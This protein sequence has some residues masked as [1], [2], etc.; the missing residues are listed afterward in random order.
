VSEHVPRRR[1]TLLLHRPAFRSLFLATLG[2]GVGT[3][4]AA[5]VLT[6][7]IRDKTHSGTWVAALLVADLLPIFLIGVTLGPLID[8]LSRKRLMIGADLVRLGVFAVL[9][10]A[11]KPGE[12]V[13]LAAITGVATGFFKPAVFAGVPNL[14]DGDDEL[15]VANSL[16]SGIDNLAWMVGPLIGAALLVVS[17]PNL[18]YWINAATFLLSAVLIS[19]IPAARLQ[20][21]ESLSRGHWRDV[22]D[23]IALVL[24]TP[25]LRTVLIV[26]NVVIVGNAALNVA[27]V[28]FAKDSLNSGNFGYGVLVAATGAGLII[29]SLLAPFVLEKIGLRRL[30]PCSVGLMGVGAL[31][32][33]AAPTVWVAAPLIA[34]ATLGNGAAIVCNQLLVQRGAPDTMRG[35]AIAVLMSSTSL[36]IVCSMA[37]TG[38]LTN[39]FGGRALWVVAGCI[40]LFGSALAYVRTRA[41]RRVLETPA[42]ADRIEAATQV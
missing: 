6:V 23:G 33:A 37:I 29:G 38:V 9:P 24:G 22:R 25:Q 31:T 2:S 11:H 4:L 40:Y 35:R 32:A 3:Y 39:E 1:L 13:A 7:S 27:E 42:L 17:G 28:F 16:L 10:F 5:L 12:I 30:Y 14:V 34:I 41:L 19:G 20:S 21:E 36:T 15:A 26:W 8:R 18:A